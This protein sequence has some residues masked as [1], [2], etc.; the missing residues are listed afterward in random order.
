MR[1]LQQLA[2]L[3]DG[4]R[5]AHVRGGKE[6]QLLEAPD[7]GGPDDSVGVLLDDGAAGQGGAAHG[8]HGGGGVLELRAQGGDE[9]VEALAQALVDVHTRGR[10]GHQKVEDEGEGGLHIVTEHGA[11]AVG[12]EGQG[13]ECPYLVVERDQA[14]GRG[15][16]VG[17]KG[18]HSS[19]PKW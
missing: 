18:E 10:D 7:G 14:G 6:L 12:Y 11:A 13:V 4:G 3:R 8:P 5:K 1:A 15:G 9:G 16:R 19:P 2:E 17:V